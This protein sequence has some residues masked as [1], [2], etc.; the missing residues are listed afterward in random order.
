MLPQSS[1]LVVRLCRILTTTPAVT[2]LYWRC[3]LCNME[4][5][6]IS[7]VDFFGCLRDW[8]S[9]WSLLGEVEPCSL[10]I[11]GCFYGVSGSQQLRDTILARC[12]RDV[13][14]N[15]AYG[16]FL[17]RCVLRGSAWLVFPLTLIV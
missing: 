4:Y 2:T 16:V 5:G 14:C 8:C 17:E 13:V 6:G 9:C 7:T 12:S 3:V 15:L 1:G 10:S 11:I